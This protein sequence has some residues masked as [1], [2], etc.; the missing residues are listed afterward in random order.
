MDLVETDLQ[1]VPQA[2]NKRYFLSKTEDM[3]CMNYRQEQ[4]LAALPEGF[5]FCFVLICVLFP[6]SFLSPFPPPFL[7]SSLFPSFLPSCPPSLFLKL[8]SYSS[9]SALKEM[10]IKRNKE[11]REGLR[12]GGGKAEGLSLKF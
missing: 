4:N 7:P 8:T 6:L 3:R 12:E 11:G 9:L 2:S 1:M 10:M 5:L